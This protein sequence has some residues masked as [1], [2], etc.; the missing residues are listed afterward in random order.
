MNR[1]LKWLGTVVAATVLLSACSA[2]RAGENESM[3]AGE[4]AYHKISATEAK[5]MMDTGGVTVVDVR[6]RDE[7]TAGHIAG[8]I[9]V[10]NEEIAS[11][12]PELLPKLDAVLL[13]Y[14]RTGV[15]SKQAA[16]KL[17][18][19]GYQN[20]YDMGGIVDWPYETVLGEGA[21]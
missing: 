18:K 9:L 16:D 12:Q 6:R 21:V 2:N 15:R 20:V 5:R 7:Y 10:P 1:K 4:G 19:L 8:A 17:V 3:P 13:V 11:V 14:C